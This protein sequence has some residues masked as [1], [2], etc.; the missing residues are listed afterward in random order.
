MPLRA[1]NVA[2]CQA[3]GS[4]RLVA[5][6]KYL[7]ARRW[8]LDTKADSPRLWKWKAR[9]MRSTWR[10][11][12]KADAWP[13]RPWRFLASSRQCARELHQLDVPLQRQLRVL[14]A[15]VPSHTGSF[16]AVPLGLDQS[17]DGLPGAL[18]SFMRTMP[19]RNQK[20]RSG[21]ATGATATVSAAFRAQ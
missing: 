17:F 12:V 19:T 2:A 13:A 6:A 3:H 16:A 8:L 7:E 21:A 9:S 18:R 4:L 14:L 11:N 10:P 15:H 5:A 20:T 1:G